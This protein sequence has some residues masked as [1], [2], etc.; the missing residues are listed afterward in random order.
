M[1]DPTKAGEPRRRE[2][3][4]GWFITCDHRVVD[5]ADAARLLRWIAEVIEE[6]MRLTVE[7]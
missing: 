7:P 3:E 2:V 1:P 5:G 6:P 4:R